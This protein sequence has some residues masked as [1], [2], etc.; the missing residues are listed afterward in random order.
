M[1]TSA[2]A[3]TTRCASTATSCAARWW[4]KAATSASRSAAASRRRWPACASTPTRSTTRPA[5]TPPTTRSTS[6]SCWAWPIADGELTLEQRNALLPTM[7]DDVA[8]LVLR[9]NYFQ[10]QALSI[11]RLLAPGAAR[12]AGAL[13][14]LPGKA[15]VA[16]TAPSSSCRATTSWPQRKA[17]GP[18]PDH[19]RAGGAA[20]L[21][22]DVAV[23]RAGGLRPARGRVDRDGAAALLS[24]GLARAVRRLHPEA[25]AAARDH[26]H[27]RAQQH[28]QPRRARPS[29]TSWRS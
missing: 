1:P 15:S 12:R 26:R 13:H 19:A 11:G 16:W 9:D 27:A 14:A 23:R 22:Q 18:G 24:R 10:T 3:P 20:G 4:P 7:T 21:Q 17:R 5:S 28:G 2:T 25:S 29:C 8:A 6:R